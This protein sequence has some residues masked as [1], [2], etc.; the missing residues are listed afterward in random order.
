MD[1]VKH[2]EIPFTMLQ[3]PSNRDHKALDRG[4]S[5]DTR[6]WSYVP[7][8]KGWI[9]QKI[10]TAITMKGEHRVTDGRNLT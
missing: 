9:Q 7:I 10:W 8:M 3:V 6:L 2:P 5:W 1:H 4:T